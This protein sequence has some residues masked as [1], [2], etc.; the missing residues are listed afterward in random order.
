MAIG[1]PDFLPNIGDPLASQYMQ[2]FESD[3]LANF[4]N[5]VIGV[6]PEVSYGVWGYIELT[7][8]TVARNIGV[9][10]SD[11]HFHVETKYPHMVF[12]GRGLATTLYG[13]KLVRYD[14]EH[15]ITLWTFNTPRYHQ[16][17]LTISLLST[18]ANDCDYYMVLWYH[19]I[20]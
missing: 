14:N 15:D 12:E 18:L 19:N 3:S 9:K 20:T 6:V 7:G 13:H 16:R 2:V 5:E 1:H 8:Q 17:E 4:T 10:I 11:R